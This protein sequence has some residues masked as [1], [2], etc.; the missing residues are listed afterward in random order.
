MYACVYVCMRGTVLLNHLLQV[1]MY[2]CVYILSYLKYSMN[3]WMYA[4]VYM[5]ACMHTHILYTYILRKLSQQWMPWETYTYIH[6]Y[7]HT[8]IIYTCILRKLSQQW[9]PWETYTYIHTYIHTY[10]IRAYSENCHDNECPEKAEQRP[11]R[12]GNKGESE[13]IGMHACVYVYMS[14]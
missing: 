13:H 8:Y 11:K 3:V 5:Y 7:M 4:C 12:G 2:V 1:C 9:M 14:I 6:T 10:N